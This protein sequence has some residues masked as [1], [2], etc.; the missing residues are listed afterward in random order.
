MTDYEFQQ[1][2][3]IREWQTLRKRICRGEDITNQ[4]CDRCNYLESMLYL[5]Y[6]IK[7]TR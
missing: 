3:M 4:L 1:Y 6:G 5:E 2:A 7:L